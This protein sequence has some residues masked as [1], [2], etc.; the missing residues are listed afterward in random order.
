MTKS[1]PD[2]LRELRIGCDKSMGQ[3]AREIGVT[4]V[5]YSQVENGKMPP[6]P[7]GKV[8]YVVLAKALNADWKE[9]QT[10][11]VES[12]GSVELNVSKAKPGAASVLVQFGRAIDDGSL[13][14]SQI[15]G[16][17]RIL[18]GEGKD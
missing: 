1:F 3:V 13:T 8:D 6:F 18:E 7:A 5:Y 17:R 11:A 10:L 9:L 4:T 16:M 12:R 14:E 2:R 15:E